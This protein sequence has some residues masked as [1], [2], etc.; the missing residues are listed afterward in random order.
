MSLFQCVVLTLL[1][2]SV[3]CNPIEVFSEA[4]I[5]NA[6]D[7][8]A[9]LEDYEPETSNMVEEESHEQ[10]VTEEDYADYAE[11][12]NADLT[13]KRPLI[14]Y[15]DI[16]VN[17][18]RNAGPCTVKGC[19]WPKSS[20]GFVN[21]PVEISSSY[22]ENARKVIIKG[23]TSLHSTTCIRFV[24]RAKQK[25][26]LSFFPGVG[27]WSYLGRQGGKQEVSLQK[28]GCISHQTVQH[29]VLHALGFHH[30]QVRSDRDKHVVILKKNILPGKESNFEKIAT[31]NLRTPYDYNSVMHYGRYAFSIKKG[32]LPT[33]VPKPD[34]NVQIG[35]A[36][37]MSRNDILRVNRLY[38]C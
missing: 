6:E 37:R 23:L 29:E 3:R 25:D 16:A 27:C 28:S 5:Y 33:I 9:A 38:Q 18:S 35:R 36:T 21:V 22:D 12:D 17:P 10:D 26:Y 4:D 24:W 11:A 34:P 13:R 8:M 7:M 1:I 15:G 30:E 19:K 14:T 32:K 2:G 31:N 20:K